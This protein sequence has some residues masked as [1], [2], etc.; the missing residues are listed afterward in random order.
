MLANGQGAGVLVLVV[1][2]LLFGG[3]LALGIVLHRRRVEALRRWAAA[4]GWTYVG[5][6][7]SLVRRWR[8]QPFGQGHAQ[9]TSDVLVGT[10]EGARALSF[11]YAWT[12]G[13]GKDQTTHTAHVVAL[14]LPATLPWVEVTPQGL[15]ARLAKVF[16]AQDID[17]ELQEFNDAF[18]VASGDARVAHAIIH[19][20]HMEALLAGP[21]LPWRIE[22]ADVLTWRLGGTNLAT[23]HPALVALRDVRDA[24]PRHV[25]QDHGW[26]P[27]AR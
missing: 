8:G 26:D 21:R 9:R 14:G 4:T 19:P 5:S 2:V 13:S 16:G 18:R 15:G 25:W 23:I 10:F 3:A 24:V 27:V 11:A 6:D 20:R 12:T 7:A 17:F 1:P 22:G